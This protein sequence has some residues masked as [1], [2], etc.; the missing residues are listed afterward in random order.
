MRPDRKWTEISS[1]N[2]L[3]HNYASSVADSITTSIR[4]SKPLKRRIE[5]KAAALGC[6]KNRVIVA[7]L[8]RY[9]LEDEQAAYRTEAR[10][11]SLLA[12]KLDRGD[13]G[14]DKLVESDFAQS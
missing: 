2:T 10:R 9:L 8:E 1:C 14:W 13:P 6:A 7:A 12:A 5:K 11:Q 4:L 3:Q